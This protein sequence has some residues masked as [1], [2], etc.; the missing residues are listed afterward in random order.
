MCLLERFA[1]LVL[2]FGRVERERERHRETERETQARLTKVGER[3]RMRRADTLAVMKHKGR[4]RPKL[5]TSVCVSLS[6]QF[7]RLLGSLRLSHSWIT[8]GSAGTTEHTKHP[9]QHTGKVYGRNE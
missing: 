2:R 6:S 4:L 7:G 9:K 1:G 8:F 5:Q 3:V